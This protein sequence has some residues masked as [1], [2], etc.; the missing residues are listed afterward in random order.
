MD[1]L[2]AKLLRKLARFAQEHVLRF[3][4]ELDDVSRRKLAD[5]IES[6]DLDLIDQLAKRS[7]SGEPAGVS[8]DFEPAEVM[9]LPRTTEEHA[10]F[11][12]AR[13]GGEELLR[14]ERAACV[15]VAGGQGTR[16]G[17][18]APKGTYPIGAVSG[19]SIFQLH[20]EKI[21]A[22]AARYDTHI[23]LFVMTSPTNDPATRTFFQENDNFGLD[24]ADLFFFVQG[25]V[26]AVDFSGKL[27][28]DARDHIFESPNGHG[29]VLRALVDSG[30]LARMRERDIT[31]IFHFQVD[32]VLVDAAEPV[33][34]GFHHESGAQMSSKVT[35]KRDAKEPVGVT[36]K[37]ADGRTAVVEYM[38]LTDE[39]TRRTEPDGSLTF[40][41]ANLCIFWYTVDFV[42]TVGTGGGLPFHFARKKIPFIDEQGEC[43]GPAEPNGLKFE[44]FVFDALPQ[45]AKTFIME[46]SRAEEFAPVKNRT[47]ED[48]VDS[49]RLA[50][51]ERFGRWL[52][53]CGVEVPRGGDGRAVYPIEISPLYALDE[54][55]LKRKLPDRLEI[56]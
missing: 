12:R 32:N 14:E 26:P 52:E 46:I 31:Q 45:A 2:H 15:V 55:E 5:Q 25:T 22:L 23:P 29:G 19:K 30:A 4:D 56:D 50:M 10:A 8:F 43:I 11:E 38:D 21:R 9:R 41:A 16:L 24:E 28:L 39:Q 37:R 47:G 1:D 48:S 13:G 35:P 3:W 40:W 18:D 27:I 36:V 33:F 34:L 42:E 17:Y 53:S 44:T 54:G 51:T 7:L 6:L 20:V 49:A